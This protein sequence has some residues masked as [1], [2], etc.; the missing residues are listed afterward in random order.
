MASEQ[1]YNDIVNGWI[2]GNYDGIFLMDIIKIIYNYYLLKIESNLLNAKEQESFLNLLFDHF[3]KQ[4]DDENLKLINTNLLYRGSEHE[5]KASKFHELCDEKGPTITII[6]NEHEHIFGG[7][8]SASWKETNNSEDV[9]APGSFLFTIKPSCKIYDLKAESEG[10][11]M[12]IGS[13]PDYGPLFGDGWDLYIVDDCNQS[14]NSGGLADSYNGD[15][16][17]MFGG[18]SHESAYIGVQFH[19][20]D[21]EVFSIELIQ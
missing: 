17:E 1:R 19:V 9:S 12:E 6:H 10:C 4:K 13:D 3:N 8:A 11:E 2:K 16:S 21:Y 18:Y 14:G 7:Y 5:F 20:I 15:S